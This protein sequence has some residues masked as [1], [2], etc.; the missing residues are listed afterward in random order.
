MTT[1]SIPQGPI[2]T[3]CHLSVFSLNR[4]SIP[5]GPINTYQ[6]TYTLLRYT[7]F[8]F[9]KVQLIPLSGRSSESPNQVSI[10]QGPINTRGHSTWRCSVTVSIPQGPINTYGSYDAISCYNVS[11]P[12]GPI[13]TSQKLSDP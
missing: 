1:V 12:Q 6:S 4:V 8:Q 3:Q 7:L 10:P 9:R 11:I 5:Q 2:N 13:N